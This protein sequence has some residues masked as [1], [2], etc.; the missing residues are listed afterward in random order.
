MA[1]QAQFLRPGDTID[2]TPVADVA[3]GE[4]VVLGNTCFVANAPIAANKT[5]ALHTRGI[6]RITKQAG[7]AISIGEGVFWDD[8][9]NYANKTGTNKYFGPAVASAGAGDATVD[10]SLRSLEASESEQ[11]SLADLSDV[12]TATATAGFVL[13]GDGSD[14]DAKK[15]E[16]VTL[17]ALTS[18]IALP[19]VLYGNCV[20]TGAEDKNVATMPVNA[21]IVECKM[22]ARDAQ[23]ASVKLHQGT[24]GADDIT[25][26]VAKGTTDDA[27]VAFTRIIEEKAVVNAATVV[28]ANFSAAGA[29]DVWLLCVPV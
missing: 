24:A 2:Y 22:I 19:F 3:G 23:A 5:G 6:F 8:A 11:L 13:V 20:A 29:V 28:K 27:I 26:A 21:R 9:N 18:G 17:K 25:V 12:G 10:V 16:P 7:V 15:L 4:V 1:F 14:F